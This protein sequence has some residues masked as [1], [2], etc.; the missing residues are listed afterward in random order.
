MQMPDKK[1]LAVKLVQKSNVWEMEDKYWPDLKHSNILEVTNTMF[2][3]KLKVK[4]YLMPILSNVLCLTVDE[5]TFLNDP[6]NFSWV[7]KEFRQILTA[8]EYLHNS[9]YCHLDIKTD[10]IMLGWKR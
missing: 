1:E 4:L 3:D 9:G 10:N 2:I 6:N 7:K 5:D 8:I